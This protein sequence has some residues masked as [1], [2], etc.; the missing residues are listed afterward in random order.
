MDEKAKTDLPV[1]V[2]TSA[3]TYRKR[4]SLKSLVRCVVVLT[5]L[6]GYLT[7]YR[8]HKYGKLPHPSLKEREKVFLSVPNPESALAVSREYATH[9]H[10]AGSDTDFE[11]AKTILSLFQR[12]FGIEPPSTAPIF[13]AGSSESRNATLLLTTKDAPTS[14]TAWVDIYYPVLNTA[15]ERSLDILS[16]E[17]QVLWS[18]NVEEDGDPL[19]KEAH[20]YKDAVPAWHGLSTDGDVT[21]Q[22]VYANY[23][24]KEDYDY[25]DSI[26]VN[27]TGKV[28]LT[29]YGEIFRG[30]KIKGAEERGAVGVLIYSDPRDDGFVTSSNGYTSYPHGPA[31]NP[32]AVQRGS[33][34]YLS[35]YPGDPTTPGYP[36]Y[37]DAERQAASNIPN[38]PSLPISWS[39]AQRLLKEIGEIHQLEENGMRLLSGQVS[40]NKVRLVN[41]VDTKVTPIWNTMAAI[42]GHIKDE[43]VII[44]NHRDAWV[45]GAA[46]PTSGTVSLHEI[47]KGFG[48]LLRT[49]WKPLRTVVF[50][51]WDGEEYGLIGST[52]WGEDFASWIPGHVVTYLNIDVSVSGSRFNLGGSPS[53]AHLMRQSALDVPHPTQAGKTLWD[54][55]DDE[56][57]F[58][59]GHEV[60][61]E[62]MVSYEKA[63]A[64]RRASETGVLPLGSGSDYTVFL[65]RLGVAST[66]E[67]FGFTNTDAIY[68]YHSIYDSQYWQ[69]IFGDPGFHRHVAVAQHLGLVG[70]RVID[71]II[72]PLNTTQYALE[73]DQYLDKVEEL[74]QDLP[75]VTDF[76][77]LRKSIKDLQAAS[78]KLDGE[79]VAAEKLLRKLLHKLLKKQRSHRCTKLV[80]RVKNLLNI[81]PDRRDTEAPST[82]IIDHVWGRIYS[83]ILATQDGDID[84]PPHG[85]P[86]H[87]QEFIKAVKR[88]REVNKRLIAFERGFISE[89]G[90]KDREWYRHLGVAPGK[91]LGY[92]ATTLPGLTESLTIE[93]NGT[94]AQYEADRLIQLLDE[95]SRTIHL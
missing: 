70:L 2:T 69:E 21:G 84:F 35:K 37:K 73:L 68:H 39:N 26:G 31:R 85:R 64:A 24:K 50:A 93:K 76:G 62:F 11:D 40:E 15:L 53:L 4:R 3:P 65:Q 41:H 61:Q 87:W 92:G 88:V 27:L 72:L 38:I 8:Y 43:V 23:G 79:K 9:P 42:P 82:D 17:G 60:D 83:D 33:V 75:I 7:F 13:P 5:V 48:T 12:E 57:P 46:D 91:W 52:E 45:M 36:A 80:N 29:R 14:P 58:T 66:D 77:S 81:S 90:I 78:F 20:R 47:I 56:G 55:K 16:A 28:V 49:G 86:P 32:N 71:S 6:G 30:L 34:Q 67:G 18:A 22:L 74:S 59:M 63:E 94:L 51:S 1:V 25:L 44:G 54:A 95:L 10:L 19:D 89:D